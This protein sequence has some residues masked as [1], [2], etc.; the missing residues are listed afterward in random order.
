LDPLCICDLPKEAGL[1]QAAPVAQRRL[2]LDDDL[3][4]HHL[5]P[6][7]GCQDQADAEW[8][9]IRRP[10]RGYNDTPFGRAGVGRPKGVFGV[11]S[12]YKRERWRSR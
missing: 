2:E 9:V 4:R 1:F 7:G 3:Q 11:F 8:M 5:T 6:L 10:L 12:Y